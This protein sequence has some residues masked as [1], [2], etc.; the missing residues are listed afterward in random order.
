MEVLDH[1]R[2][3]V[4]GVE[5]VLDDDHVTARDGLR[6]VFEDPHVAARLGRLAV[7]RDLEEVER[8]RDRHLSHQ[9]GKER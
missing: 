6:Q 8:E 4:A 5:D 2:E 1:V 7:R 9:I 3:R